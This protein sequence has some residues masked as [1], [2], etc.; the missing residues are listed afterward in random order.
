MLFLLCSSHSY[1]SCGEKIHLA[2][3]EMIRIFPKSIHDSA[4][5]QAALKKLTSGAQRLRDECIMSED[6]LVTDP[7]AQTQIVI[8]CAYDI[9]LAAKQLVVL[10]E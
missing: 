1:P 6:P 10:F 7:Q 2:V 8:H 9:A 5:H 4:K 3:V